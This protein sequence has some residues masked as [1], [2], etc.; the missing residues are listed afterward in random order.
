MT[1]D[2]SPPV[3]QPEADELNR[4]LQFGVDAVLPKEEPSF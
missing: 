4:L 2:L 1:T 3:L